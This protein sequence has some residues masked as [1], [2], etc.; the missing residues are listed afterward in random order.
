MEEGAFEAF[1]RDLYPALCRY[2]RRSVDAP[3]AEDV[4][5][6]ALRKI[7]ERNEPNPASEQEWR[8]L[9]SFAFRIVEGNIRT[10]L[11]GNRRYSLL[12]LRIAQRSEPD[13]FLEASADGQPGWFVELPDAERRLL[14][15]V[16][17]GVTVAEIG[18]VMDLEPAVVSG[19]LYRARQRAKEL[20][21]KEASDDL[22]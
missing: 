9:A 22:R 20:I 4:A 1:F 13:L 18:A 11:R 10:R 12:L 8:R 3:T 17:D 14:Q 16:A 21:A 7:W 5:S 2:A 15:L 19:R 6:D